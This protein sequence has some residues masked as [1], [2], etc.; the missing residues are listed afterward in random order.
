MADKTNLDGQKFKAALDEFAEVGLRH[1]NNRLKET[2]TK[3]RKLMHVGVYFIALMLLLPF[4]MMC[5]SRRRRGRNHGSQVFADQPA[6][7]R[8]ERLPCPA[9]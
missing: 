7:R 2:L 5:R 3:K 4:L 6:L 1:S 9:I 8:L